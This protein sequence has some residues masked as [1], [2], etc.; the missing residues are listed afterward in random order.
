[1][2]L[3]RVGDYMRTYDY[4]LRAII[5]AIVYFIFGFES[6]MFVGIINIL[7]CIENKK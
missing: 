4:L 3:K 1:M 5:L 2:H 7:D 6:A